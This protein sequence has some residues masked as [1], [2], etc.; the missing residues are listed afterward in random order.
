V[1]DAFKGSLIVVLLVIVFVVYPAYRQAE[2]TDDIT[3]KT[4]NAAIIEF[5]DTV[6]GKGYVDVRDYNVFLRSLDA[7][8]AVF[9]V[10][11]EY[12]KKVTQPTYID[13]NNDLTFQ[14]NFT[15]R[16]DGYFTT[17][18]LNTLFPNT[19]I[20]EDDSSRH[21]NMHEG[22]IFNVRIHSRGTTLATRLRTFLFH[23]KQVSI[24]KKYGGMVRSEAP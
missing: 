23:G 13:P 3:D 18:I 15:V 20:A 4:A 21:Y 16:F 17:D 6:R 9:D 24:V 2:K 8:R 5:V 11:L 10:S 7:S 19:A 22:D 12:Y 14:N 1:I